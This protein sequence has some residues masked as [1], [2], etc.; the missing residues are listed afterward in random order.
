[1]KPP[2]VSVHI[3]TYNQISFIRDTLDSVLNQDYP[4]FEVVVADDGSTDGTAE[5]IS[6]YS[7]K[8]PEKIIPLIG[9]PNLGI[10]GN[11]NRCLN[12]CNGKYIAFMGGDDLFLPGKLT[13]QVD[14]ME[15]DIQ[16]VL[17]GHQVQVFYDHDTPSH[18]QRLR[19]YSGTGAAWAI[20]NGSPYG[21]TA[22]MVRAENI[23]KNG[24]DERLPV[25][26]D[27][28]LWID[29]L[30]RGGKFGYVEGILAK[31]RRHSGNVTNNSEKCLTDIIEMFNILE[32]EYPNYLQS[33]RKGRRNQAD[34]YKAKNL[35][36]EGKHLGAI[37]L[38]MK[39]YAY[40]PSRLIKTISFKSRKLFKGSL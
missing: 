35:M 34:M 25:V 26:S 16:R 28:K 39:V 32:K 1:M 22:V 31:Y 24:F 3:I 29:V 11:S 40:S 36:A 7:K 17:C 9:G 38:V 37:C 30:M 18:I 6:E 10:T 23:P 8:N 20:E 5:V 14:W 4:N 13:A 21:A 2:L 12:A 19:L 33:I 27:Q 15:K